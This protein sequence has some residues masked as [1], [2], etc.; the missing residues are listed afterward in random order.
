M[1]AKLAIETSTGKP[2][3]PVVSAS[4]YHNPKDKTPVLV[5]DVEDLTQWESPESIRQQVQRKL[6]AAKLPNSRLNA[7]K[8]QR[9]ITRLE[10]Q[11]EAVTHGK[12]KVKTAKYR[13][14][15]PS[16]KTVICHT[17][18]KLKHVCEAAARKVLSV[19]DI[20]G[21]FTYAA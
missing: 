10:R 3:N 2:F 1:I 4:V 5:L 9:L 19:K 6:D 20:L 13:V 8:K 11:L 7:E 17:K 21:D 12:V 16:G 14:T 18:S 15:F